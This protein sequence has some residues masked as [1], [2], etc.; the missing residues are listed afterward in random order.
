MYSGDDMMAVMDLIFMC[1]AV[2]TSHK[3]AIEE[4]L[5]DISE[6][7]QPGQ[8]QILPCPPLLVMVQVSH[9][10]DA[11]PTYTYVHR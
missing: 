5:G 6:D 1:T 2:G 10:D 8:E 3:T 11:C 9:T 4:G 7:I